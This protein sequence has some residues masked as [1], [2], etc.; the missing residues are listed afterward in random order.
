MIRGTQPGGGGE[1]GIDQPWGVLSV[2]SGMPHAGTLHVLQV[3]ATDT[4]WIWKS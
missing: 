2:H 4:F 3:Y 1:H